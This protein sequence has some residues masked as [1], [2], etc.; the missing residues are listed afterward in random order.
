M[1]GMKRMLGASRIGN[2]GLAKNAVQRVQLP[3]KVSEAL[4]A[5][6]GEQLIYFED[7]DGNVV[8]MSEK[9]VAEALKQD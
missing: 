8:I 6:V 9:K 7:D 5:Q 4:G 2:C 3:N 1:K